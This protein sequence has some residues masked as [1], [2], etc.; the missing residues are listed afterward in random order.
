MS[1]AYQEKLKDPRWQKKRLEIL[2][3]DEWCCQICNDKKSTLH[4]HHLFYKDGLD[5]WEYDDKDL[6]TL[7]DYHHDVVHRLPEI[8]HQYISFWKASKAA[9]EP[10]L[11]DYTP[12]D[13]R[14][15]LK[16]LFE[17]FIQGIAIEL[18]K[19]KIPAL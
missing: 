3:R 19:K 1:N 18:S 10:L 12:E 9:F 6:V 5:P 8:P 17:N 11:L 2:K 15:K 14:D 4:V 7:C 16:G 13:S